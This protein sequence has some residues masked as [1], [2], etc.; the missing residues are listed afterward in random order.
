MNAAF[1][2]SLMLAAVLVPIATTAQTERTVTI[3]YLGN[4]SPALESNLVDAFRNGLHQL[5]YTIP[6]S[7]LIRADEVIQ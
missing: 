4:S 3:G 6:Q 2:F 5:G 7:V 1:A